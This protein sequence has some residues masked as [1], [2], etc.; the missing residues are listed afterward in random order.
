M[1]FESAH[2]GDA[3]EV[4]PTVRVR[5]DQL[6]LLAQR[7]RDNGVPLDDAFCDDACRRLALTESQ[8]DNLLD[9]TLADKHRRIEQE[10]CKQRSLEAE[11]CRLD[12]E[13]RHGPHSC[14]VWTLPAHCSRG[15][16]Q[17]L[18]CMGSDQK[19]GGKLK[20]S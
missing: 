4:L 9:M 12:A 2:N 17:L 11:R 3:G 8:F 14:S 15:W 13:L 20:L 5:L 1:R 19:A 18:P 10:R 6:A 16:R 7:A